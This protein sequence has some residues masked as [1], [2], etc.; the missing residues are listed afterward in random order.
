MPLARM[1]SASEI[2]GLPDPPRTG[3]ERL[4]VA[5]VDLFY[6]NGFGAIGIDRVIS[7]AGVTKT[8][9]YK[10]FESKDDLMVAAVQLRD[11]WESQAW[12]TAI[13]KLAGDDPIRQLLAMFDV[14]DLWFN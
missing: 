4:L 6:R 3:R 7:A 11:E 12:H 9:F 13:H 5:A 1:K 2:F 8:T 10:H 14:M